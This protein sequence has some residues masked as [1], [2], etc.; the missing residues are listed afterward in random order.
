MEVLLFNKNVALLFLAN[1]GSTDNYLRYVKQIIEMY[2]IDEK[3]A[4]L[5][6]FVSGI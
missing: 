4:Y 2:R 5:K 3:R 1:K 6:H